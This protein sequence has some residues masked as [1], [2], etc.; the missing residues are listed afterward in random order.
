MPPTADQSEDIVELLAEQHREIRRLLGDVQAGGAGRQE[1]FERLLR[2]LAV[3]ETA[4]ELVVHPVVRDVANQGD[5]IVDE[6]LAEEDAAKRELSQLEV[7]G[8][9]AGGFEARLQAV[10]EA[11]LAH[12]DAE[13][14]LE[15]PALRS[16]PADDRS[17]M[18]AALRAA[19]AVA[20][21]HPHPHAPE[22]ALGNLAVGP[23]VGVVDRV[24]DA[25]RP[26]SR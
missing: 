18:A 19:E 25:L 3:H 14:A 20:P 7:M 23:F 21:T 11:V 13:E 2:L 10:A 24:R 17:R 16:L 15:F 12:A 6:R 26:A 22:S 1:A 9:D 4:E 5:R 8:V